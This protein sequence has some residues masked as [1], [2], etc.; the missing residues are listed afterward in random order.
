MD[1]SVTDFYA[2]TR[3]SFHLEGYDPQPFE[4]TIPV[5]I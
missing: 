2:F 5:A 1:P 3:D 4:E